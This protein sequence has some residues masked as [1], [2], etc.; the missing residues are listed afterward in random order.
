MI[1]AYVP[2]NAPPG[3]QAV[4]HAFASAANTDN[5][6]VM[7]SLAIAE[8]VRQVEGEADFV[9]L[10][11][12]QGLVIIEVKSHHTI[13]READGTWHLG[14]QPPTTRSPF[15]QADEAKYSVLDYLR[16][17]GIDTRRAPTFHVV[18]FTHV[19]AK[20]MLPQ[21]LE[22]H[23]WQILDS[24]DLRDPVSALN[25]VF[26]NGLQHLASHNPAMVSIPLLPDTQAASIVRALRPRFEMS[27]VP[28][29]MRRARQ[30]ELAVFLDEQYEALD[31]MQ[32]NQ[33]VLFTGP[34]G[35]GKTFLAMEAVSREL[36][37][38]KHG[39]LLCFN[40]LLGLQLR[41]EMGGRPGLIVGTL[42]QELTRITRAAVPPSA[43]ADFWQHTLPD[44]ALETLLSNGPESADFLVIDEVQDIANPAYID[45][46][47]LLVDGGLRDGRVLLFGDFEN[48]SVYEVGDNRQLLR[49]RIADLVPY[50]LV[51]NCRNLP[52]IGSTANHLGK[53]EPGYTKYRRHDNGVD[54]TFLPYARDTDQSDLLAQ[55]VKDLE[56]E[57]FRLEDMVVLSPR[58]QGSAAEQTSDNRLKQLLIP[59]EPKPRPGKLMFSTI[60]AFKGLEAP[61]VILTDLDASAVP[62]FDAALYVGITRAMDRLVV[63]AERATLVAMIGGSR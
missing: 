5:W 10:V 20:T 22:W 32:E 53:L 45:V 24:Q 30:D 51:S 37:Q 17:H 62:N 41:V 8:H 26:S 6:V 50:R 47:D 63:I 49:D 19:R 61:A 59:A 18:W 23:P 36:R 56:S 39:R 40:R 43:G 34:A 60:Q 54:P 46:L 52:R 28:A 15:Q 33:R 9:V 29:D 58:R 42:H 38:G 57:G 7:H 2:A 12:G 31:T 21:T 48:Q 14:Q 55:A 1:P 11:P 3:E 16:R 25:R 4:F 35:S 27:T 13:S 44:R